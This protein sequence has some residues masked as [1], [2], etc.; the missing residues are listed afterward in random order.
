M[1]E[2]KTA[3]PEQAADILRLLKETG[4]LSPPKEGVQLLNPD[5]AWRRCYTVK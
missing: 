2:M 4:I 3:A 5:N 1:D